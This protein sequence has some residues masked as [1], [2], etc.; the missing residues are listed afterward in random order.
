VAKLGGAIGLGVSICGILLLVVIYMLCLKKKLVHTNKNGEQ[1]PTNQYQ[2]K[3]GHQQL[4]IGTV[5]REKPSLHEIT[6]VSTVSYS[7][8]SHDTHRYPVQNI[9][10]NYS[11]PVNSSFSKSM[12]YA[13]TNPSQSS[14]N[15]QQQQQQS[16][17]NTHTKRNMN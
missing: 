9:H 2:R 4:K 15:N 6:S 16:I 17:R 13:H 8:Q 12:S 7:K 10:N 11:K 1:Q 3:K 5:P 14:A